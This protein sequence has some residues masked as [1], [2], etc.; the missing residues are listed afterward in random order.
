MP[1]DSILY[2]AAFI[3]N[4]NITIL[5]STLVYIA[6]QIIRSIKSILASN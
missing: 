2:Y 5:N 1:K 4:L 6:V 3:N